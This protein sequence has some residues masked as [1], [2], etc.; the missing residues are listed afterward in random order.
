[1]NAPVILS[2]DADRKDHAH[3]RALIEVL[4]ARDGNKA[5]FIMR[6]HIQL[7]LKIVLDALGG[8]DKE[9]L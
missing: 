8:K 3:H 7:T 4:S 6:G 2:P 1:L 9:S 5:K